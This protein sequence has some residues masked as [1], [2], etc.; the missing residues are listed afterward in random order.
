MQGWIIIGSVII[1]AVS[2]GAIYD[3]RTRRR[4]AQVNTEPDRHPCGPYDVIP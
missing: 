4:G 1:A 3:I 2:L